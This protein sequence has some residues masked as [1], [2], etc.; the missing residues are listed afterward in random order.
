MG[1]IA[2]GRLNRRITIQQRALSAAPAPVE[3]WSTWAEVWAERMDT[4]G[5]ET[6]SAGREET[7]RTAV[8][9]I[10]YRSGLKGDMRIVESDWTVEGDSFWDI[11]S[12][13][14]IGFREG[15]EILA[16]KR[17]G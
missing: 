12:F 14:E 7:E 1:M 4:R 15:W 5:Q 13:A 17:G 3:T 2:S 9:R 16:V 6:F 11:E 10:R 8:F